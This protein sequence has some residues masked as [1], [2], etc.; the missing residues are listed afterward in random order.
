[1]NNG[2]Q[3][4]EEAIKTA[5]KQPTASQKF[6]V[7]YPEEYIPTGY[8]KVPYHMVFDVKYDLRH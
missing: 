1:M 6:F 7:L 8:Q 3:L 2:N 5:L 4:K